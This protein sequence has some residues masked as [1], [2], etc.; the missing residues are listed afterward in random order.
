[1]SMS[2]KHLRFTLENRDYPYGKITPIWTENRREGFSAEDLLSKGIYPRKNMDREIL[3]EMLIQ[4]FGSLNHSFEADHGVYFASPESI[5]SMDWSAMISI[6]AVV[7][8]TVPE[9]SHPLRQVKDG[10]KTLMISYIN[11]YS[12]LIN[13]GLRGD[14]GGMKMECTYIPES[15]WQIFTTEGLASKWMFEV[16]RTRAIVASGS[17]IAWAI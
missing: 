12:A 17:D 16:Q 15:L 10:L 13:A 4:A 14:S 1:M 2:Y 7:W 11:A 6:I 5:P 8:E 3:A 9:K